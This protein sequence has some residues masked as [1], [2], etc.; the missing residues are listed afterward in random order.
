MN[1]NIYDT[2]EAKYRTRRDQKSDLEISISELPQSAK[3]VDKQVLRTIRSMFPKYNDTTTIYHGDIEDCGICLRHTY[4]EQGLIRRC[5]V[6]ILDT[7]IAS[8]DK[9]A[10]QQQKVTLLPDG[11]H[12]S[13]RDA[14]K[15]VLLH[16]RSHTL[17]PKVYGRQIRHLAACIGHNDPEALVDTVEEAYAFWFDDSISGHQQ[18]YDEAAYGYERLDST[19]LKYFYSC[20]MEASQKWGI[21]YVCTN[22]K[23]IVRNSIP[24]IQDISL[25]QLIH[26][27]IAR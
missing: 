13:P 7:S 22:L 4:D 2:G 5:N 6:I 27:N 15:K 8:M 3:A 16:E 17:F 23:K 18:F 10:L 11:K 25:P 21:D 9:E 24:D 14:L 19:Q 1:Y 26:Q 12:L 20:F